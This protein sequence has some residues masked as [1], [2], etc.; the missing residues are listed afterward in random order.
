MSEISKD[1]FEKEPSYLTASVRINQLTKQFDTNFK[2]TLVVNNLNLNIYE[3]QITG[4]LGHNGAG[5]STTIFML[6][7]I[8]APTS[9]TAEILGFDLRFQMDRIRS[10][11]GFCPQNDI[12][13]DLLTVYEHLKLISSVIIRY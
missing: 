8:I 7:G 12:H 2:K 4:L 5:K 6:S 9:G 10:Q 1:K 3:N 13:Y 11:M